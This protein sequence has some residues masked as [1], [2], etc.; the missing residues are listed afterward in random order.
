MKK[1]ISIFAVVIIIVT[2]IFFAKSHFSPSAEPSGS[3]GVSDSLS[4]LFFVQYCIYAPKSS[5]VTLDGDKVSYNENI[6][7]FAAE[8]KKEGRYTVTVSHEGCEAVK[9]EVY[10]S[11][12]SNELTPSLSY[13]DDYI[14]EGEA[15]SAE[16]IESLMKKCWALDYD[17]SEYNFLSE[18]E[19]LN[20]EAALADIVSALE[21]NI[22]A[23]YKT[24]ELTVTVAPI[25]SGTPSV[26]PEGENSSLLFSFEAQYS[27]NWQ[28]DSSDYKDSG[29]MTRKSM[30]YIFVEKISGEWY[31]R[32]FNISLTNSS[33]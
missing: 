20:A 33:I 18:D 3:T 29:S 16:L 13:T 5:I 27:Y 2:G 8:V 26:K 21:E 7:C 28:F 12:D 1:Y 19:R 32:S 31:I 24:G 25:E 15:K 4:E 22:S 30:P 6:N 14:K 9:K 23:G 11:A 10:I 17:L